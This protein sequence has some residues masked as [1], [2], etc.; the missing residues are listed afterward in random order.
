MSSEDEKFGPTGRRIELPARYTDPKYGKKRAAKKN[1][2]TPG[3]RPS[4]P[5]VAPKPTCGCVDVRNPETGAVVSVVKWCNRHR[6]APLSAA[7]RPKE[8]A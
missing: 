3:V 6:P 1:R 4:R 5:R 8:R 7:G 2:P